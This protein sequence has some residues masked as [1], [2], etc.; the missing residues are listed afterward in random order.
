MIDFGGFATKRVISISAL[1]LSLVLVLLVC[2]FFFKSKPVEPMPLNLENNAKELSF[3]LH[4]L[5]QEESYLGCLYW[6]QSELF[7]DETQSIVASGISVLGPKDPSLPGFIRRNAS[8]KSSLLKV[9]TISKQRSVLTQAADHEAAIIHVKNPAIFRAKQPIIIADCLHAEINK[10]RFVDRKHRSL[11]LVYPLHYYYNNYPQVGQLA[12]HIL[13]VHKKRH[14][15]PGLFYAKAQ[16]EEG[17]DPQVDEMT[18]NPSKKKATDLNLM[19]V[20]KDNFNEIKQ[21]FTAELSIL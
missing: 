2:H 20:L 7:D 18:I 12:E 10:V 8:D 17:I 5:L 21:E 1:G 15:K 11:G 14:P 13:F 6:H 3:K 9:K 19:L 4:N 16:K